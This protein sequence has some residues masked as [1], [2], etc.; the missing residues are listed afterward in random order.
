VLIEV[1]NPPTSSPGGPLLGAN[2]NSLVLRVLHGEVSFLL[3]GDIEAP[4]ERHLTRTHPNLASWVMQV[5][6][7]GSRTSTTP[8]F[9]ERVSP[10]AAVISSG[11]DSRHGHPHPEVVER[12]QKA[13]DQRQIYMTAQHGNIHFISNGRA[14][15][16][17]TQ[18]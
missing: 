6:H 7:H 17:K 1:L 15:W 9:L 11:V 14:V 18:R 13:L 5:A 4:A 10:Q 12:L 16:V 8:G 3:T 2:N